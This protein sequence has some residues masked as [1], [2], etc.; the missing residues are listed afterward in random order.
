[1]SRSQS[2]WNV[3]YRPTVPPAPTKRSNSVA[4]PPNTILLEG[5]KTSKSFFGRFR[6][7]SG[8]KK[9]KERRYS[10]CTGPCLSGD[11]DAVDARGR[12]LLFYA[13]RYGQ[14]DVAAQLIQAGCSP[15]QKDVLNNTPLHEAIEK[16]HF[17]IAEVFLEE[18]S[19]DVNILGFNGQTPLMAA[20][21]RGQTDA[22]TFLD[23]YSADVN[24]CDAVGN[25][26][27][28]CALQRG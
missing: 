4:Y 28:Y 5:K 13:A 23:R 8:D 16:G 22:L 7:H 15:N 24:I 19:A 10:T 2:L 3:Q 9:C 14:L 21:T 26:P 17:K 25:S 18:G 6:K 1:M 27:I 20:V 12:S 11:V